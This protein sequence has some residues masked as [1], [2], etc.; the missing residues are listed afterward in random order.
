MSEGRLMEG[1]NARVEEVARGA[2]P[3]T[4]EAVLERLGERKILWVLT[5]AALVSHSFNMFGYPL[6][7]GDE[8]IYTEQAWA[9]LRL[10][11][12]APYTYFYDHAPAG[13]LMLAL[14]TM[15]LPKG[16]LTFGL[17]V[18]SGRVLMLILHLASV[19][20]LF[21]I[22]R[23]LSQSLL[24]ATAATLMFFLSPLS[25][26]YQR[27]V[28][29]DNMMVFWLLLSLYLVLYHGFRL[30][31]VLAG[32]AALGIAVLNKENALFFLPVMVYLLMRS[33]RTGHMK[34][35]AVAGWGFAVVMVVS[36]YPLYALLK[37]ELLPSEV[38][39]LMNS[40]PA[41][42][43]SLIGTIGWQL[44]RSGGSI[45]DPYSQFWRFFWAKW[46]A[47]DSVIIVAGVAATSLNL[48]AGYLLRR[49]GYLVAALLCVSFAIYL[50]RGSVML[51]FYVVPILPFLAMNF[52]ITVG[53]LMGRMPWLL[54][55]PA[56]AL[57]G[58][59]MIGVFLYNARDA[60]LI[61]FVRLQEE[62]L[63]WVRENIP[64]SSIVV[65]D[66]DL[67]V[68][69]HEPGGGGPIFPRAHSHWKVAQDPA[70]Q[71]QALNNDWRR[72]DYLI[73]SNKLL[74]TFN[75]ANET[76]PIEIYDNSR[77]VA[78]FVDGDVQLQVRQVVK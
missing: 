58:G 59:L 64:P 35:F 54:G 18:G 46:W 49:T 39:F 48:L 12:L 9:V 4:V 57:G 8:G 25:V 55:L 52:G 72:V 50:A 77:M 70:V 5:L 27:M 14:W 13:W 38:A 66:D 44:Q 11:K 61:D 30:M 67:W 78:A 7:L 2:A 43:V 62:Q 68:D 34:R 33:L 63:A 19:V 6:Y 56:I 69:L 47:K 76:L 37:N 21:R 32:G 60:Y 36:V 73:M 42:H 29:L 45:L 24:A 26:Y 23:A 3:G 71:V 20:L 28:L 75:E 16:F 10:T 65:V 53:L 51:E 31:T 41:E 17:A 74:V 22:T 15:I 40:A 1:D